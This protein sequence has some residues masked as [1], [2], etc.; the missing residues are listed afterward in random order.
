MWLWCQQA[1]G[2]PCSWERSPGA[3]CAP[4]GCAVPCAD[5]SSIITHLSLN[6]Q[7]LLLKFQIL[8]F[9]SY[10]TFFFI[11]TV[12]S[13]MEDYL[14]HLQKLLYPNLVWRNGIACWPRLEKK[15]FL[16]EVFESKSFSLLRETWSQ[17]L[18]LWPS[19]EMPCLDQQGLK[20]VIMN[21]I[22]IVWSWQYFPSVCVIHVQPF[23]FMSSFNKV[24]W[25]SATC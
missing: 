16:W 3:G 24:H 6:F 9:L 15:S 1:S 13:Q 7:C 21:L 4:R 25:A 10:L 18:V 5:Y 14:F 17:Q 11:L 22:S 19:V 20:R 12:F 8:A 2:I 23:S